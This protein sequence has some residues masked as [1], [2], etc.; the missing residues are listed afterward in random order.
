M[1][2][3]LINELT[4]GLLAGGC[5]LISYLF[6]NQVKLRIINLVGSFL[7][8]CYGV[9]IVI[10]TSPGSGWTTIVLNAICFVI[11]LVWLMRYKKGKIVIKSIKDKEEQDRGS[12]DEL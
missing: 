1:N 4:L 9:A 11:H 7:F 10:V 8:T 2:W 3:G 12:D 6:T 5:V